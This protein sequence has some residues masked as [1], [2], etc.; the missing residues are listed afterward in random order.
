[1]IIFFNVVLKL[2]YIKSKNPLSVTGKQR[3]LCCWNRRGMRG[4]WTRCPWPTYPGEID[5]SV[6]AACRCLSS[7]WRFFTEAASSKQNSQVSDGVRVLRWKRLPRRRFP[8][9]WPFQTVLESCYRLCRKNQ[10]GLFWLLQLCLRV[11]KDQQTPFP[12]ITR[13]CLL[14]VFAL[15]AFVQ[16]TCWVRVFRLLREWTCFPPD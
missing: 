6:L 9:S 12:A 8:V 1:M 14:V 5:V 11:H 13:L 16:V 10:P 3:F 7:R 4:S 2:K 15:V